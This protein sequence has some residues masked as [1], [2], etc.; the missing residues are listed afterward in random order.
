MND[1][2][3]AASSALFEFRKHRENVEDILFDMRANFRNEIEALGR[4]PTII[5]GDVDTESRRTVEHKI[6]EVEAI[7]DYI[8]NNRDDACFD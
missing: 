4:D 2:L 8:R 3:Q 7:I 5:N 6:K 1:M